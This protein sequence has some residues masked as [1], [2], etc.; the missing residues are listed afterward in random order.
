MAHLSKEAKIERNQKIMRDNPGKYDRKPGQR[1]KDCLNNRDFRVLSGWLG[2]LP[3]G[4][5]SFEKV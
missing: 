1:V 5:R 4:P 3:P 2:A